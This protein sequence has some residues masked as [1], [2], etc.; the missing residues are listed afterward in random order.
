MTEPT[1]PTPEEVAQLRAAAEAAQ[2]LLEFTSA[3]VGDPPT[4]FSYDHFA[5]DGWPKVMAE[6]L[7]RCSP[8]RILALLA[9][10]QRDAEEIARHHRGFCQ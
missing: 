6:F 3:T 10:A 5:T 9:Q 7:A 4:W 8:E 1:R 2:K